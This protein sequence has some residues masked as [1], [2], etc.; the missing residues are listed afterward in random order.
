M[1]N[2]VFA[3]SCQLRLWQLAWRDCEKRGH[4]VH[5]RGCED[6]IRVVQDRVDSGQLIEESDTDSKKD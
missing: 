1:S 5:S 3:R 4:P 6:V 2:K